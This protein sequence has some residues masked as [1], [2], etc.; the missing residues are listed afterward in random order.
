MYLIYAEAV[1]RGGTGGDLATAL[2]YVNL[3]R[4]RAFG[5]TSGDIT[6]GTLTTQ[7]ILDERGRELY[8]EGHRRTDLIRFNQLT[9][10]T[11]IWPWKG[12]V[13]S[14]TAVDA[15]YNLYPIPASVLSSNPNLTQ[16][17]GY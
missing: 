6:A 3:V 17:L 12:G 2:N 15:K 1:L 14:G 13:S 10:S 7:W 9:T 8:W 4:R 11:Y 16:N 5:D